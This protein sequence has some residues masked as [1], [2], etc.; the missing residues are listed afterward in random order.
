MSEQTPTALF[1]S[2]EQDFRHIIR[3]ISE[4]LEGSGKN[5]LGEQR[6]A[7]LRKVEIEL[8][9]ADDIV[10]QLEIEIQGIPQSVRPPYTSRLKHAKADLTKYK[11]LSKD[12]HSAAARTDLLGAGAFNRSTNSD[13]PYGERSDRARLL[14]GSETLGDGSRRIAESTSIALDTES[15]GGDILTGLRA[16]R[17]QIEN[18][19]NTLQTADIHIDRSSGTIKGMIRQMHKQRFILSAIGVFF[20]VLVCFILYFKLVR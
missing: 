17:E 20:V 12:L 9:E 8:D 11:K 7:A 10:S 6:K 16:Q 18:S 13:D 19:R 2:Y 3:S 5:Q 1:D 4:K 14:A 15:M